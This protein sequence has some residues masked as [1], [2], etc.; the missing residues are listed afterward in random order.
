MLEKKRMDFNQNIVTAGV[1]ALVMDF[2]VF[3]VGPTKSGKTLGIVR[4]GGHREGQET[5]W[6]CAAREAFEEASLHVQPI[7]PPATYW[8]NS[9]GE[10]E[11]QVSTWCSSASQDVA[12]LL[13]TRR[14][15]HVITPIY[16]ASSEDDP[17]PAA[18]VKA[19]VL[20][21]PS[22]IEQLVTQTMTLSDYLEQGGRVVFREDLPMHFV[23]EPFVHLRW[24]HI[25]LHLHPEIAHMVK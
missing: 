2:F 17:L 19:L 4:L 7:Q 21:R 22:D 24:L 23:I 11:M 5:G 1:Y 14:S 16:L 10:Y 12:P 13:V 20:L 18:E 25:L 15:E 3:Q 8:G 6:E 9:P